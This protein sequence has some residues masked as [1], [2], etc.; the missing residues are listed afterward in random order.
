MP[1]LHHPDNTAPSKQRLLFVGSHHP[2]QVSHPILH[3]MLQINIDQKVCSQSLT[4]LLDQRNLQLAKH[5]TS[6]SITSKQKFR[7]YLIF[8]LCQVVLNFAEDIA[9]GFALEGEEGCIKSTREAIIYSMVNED[10]LEDGLRDIDMFAGRGCII[11]ALGTM[12]MAPALPQPRQI[13]KGLT[14]LCGSFPH[15]YI[16]ANSSPAILRHHLVC[17][18]Q[19]PF[20]A[21][22][23][24]SCSRPISRR[25]SRAAMFVICALG[26]SAVPG[27]AASMM[28][29]K[30]GVLSTLS[31]DLPKEFLPCCARK[32]ARE[33]P[34]GPA[35]IINRSVS[36]TTACSSLLPVAF[37]LGSVVSTGAIAIRV[38]DQV[39]SRKKG[40]PWRMQRIF[41]IS[42]TTQKIR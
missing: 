30:P 33:A 28:P 23:R 27:V 16:L 24:H 41:D 13:G 36:T 40:K 32:H 7:S 3:N 5:L 20:T 26:V 25:H 10:R 22:C 19:S 11:I 42:R 8:I 4:G 39:L 35:P 15:E 31:S 6:G 38:K 9:V 34:A 12:S 14:A 18:I 37:P 17:C 21:T 29:F 1:R 2:V